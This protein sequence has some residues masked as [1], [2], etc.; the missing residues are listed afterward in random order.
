MLMLLRNLEPRYELK[1]SVIYQQL[2]DI[3]EIIFVEK[4]SVDI[5]Y[6]ISY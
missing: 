4:G 1:G 3:A 5:G 2:E 6:E